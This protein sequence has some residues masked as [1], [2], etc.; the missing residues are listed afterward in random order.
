MKNTLE[1]VNAC[2]GSMGQRAIT[3]LNVPHP[4]KERALAVLGTTLEE[5]ESDGWWFNR[6]TVEFVPDSESGQII[7]PHD[8]LSF[9]PSTVGAVARG[10][11]L[12]NTATGSDVF[13]APVRGVLLRSVPFDNL[14]PQLRAY[15]GNT[16]VHQ[17]QTTYDG[18][19][20]KS[21]SLEGERERS[22]M[23]ANA[24][25]TRQVAANLILSNPRLQYIRRFSYRRFV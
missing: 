11:V 22:R 18:D 15:I 3:N 25:E 1:V 7:L 20:T 12:F 6:E 16:A 2:L 21:R 24:E 19:S 23:L 10:R 8:V 13:T 14:P 17:F 5:I 4:F 9:R